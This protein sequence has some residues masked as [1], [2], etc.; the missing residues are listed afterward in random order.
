MNTV[1]FSRVQSVHDNFGIESNVLR[2]SCGCFALDVES[3][4]QWIVSDLSDPLKGV[5]GGNGFVLFRRSGFDVFQVG[6]VSSG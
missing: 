4:T 6:I 5:I 3:E 2:D 1:G